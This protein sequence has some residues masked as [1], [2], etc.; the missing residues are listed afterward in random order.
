MNKSMRIENSKRSGKALRGLFRPSKVLMSTG[1]IG[2]V[3]A[4]LG[5][6]G[7]LSP[8][9][10]ST[11]SAL[12]SSRM[13]LLAGGNNLTGKTVLWDWQ[14]VPSNSF[15]VP[16]LNGAKAAANMA[17][18][19]LQ[20]EYGNNSDT[21]EAS[22]IKTAVASHVAGVAVGV[23]DSGLNNALCS[24]HAAGIPVVT[25][26]INGSTGAGA[27]CVDSFVGQSFVKS[28][29][30]IAQYM[31][32]KGLIK[33]GDSVF[34]P[35]E[36]PDQTYAVD[37][38]AGVNQVLSKLG[39]TCTTVGTGDNLAPTKST[40]VQYLL[41]HKTT[42]A[43]IALGGTPLAEAPA[44]VKQVGMKIPIGGF[45][46]SFPEIVTGIQNGTIVASVNQ[47]PYAQGFYAI[48]ELALKLKYGIPPSNI[49]TS[50]NSLITKANIAQFSKL[51]P[52]YQ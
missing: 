25:F 35:V 27:A 31:V 5:T 30:L 2:L 7:A 14:S 19:K 28:G 45:D 50:D 34:C 52:S 41:G 4:A 37:R 39:I 38:R 24:A 12:A 44:A 26:N 40:L 3:F 6:T 13:S 33:K 20:V 46:L 8:T 18:L 49:N 36:S 21:T 10:V 51:V 32:S 23:G 48:M 47:E 17:G 11:A 15:G 16:L 29:A 1:A 42:S 43:I 9:A 22:Q